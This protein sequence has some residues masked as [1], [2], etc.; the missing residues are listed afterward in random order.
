MSHCCRLSF[1]SRA[2][3]IFRRGR[4]LCLGM[5]RRLMSQNAGAETRAEVA[6]RLVASA[7]SW[8]SHAGVDRTSALLPIT[9]RRA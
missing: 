3:L 4:L 2:R 1:I 6:S 9:H 8:L 7:K 5:M